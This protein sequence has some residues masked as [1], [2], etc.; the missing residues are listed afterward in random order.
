MSKHTPEPWYAVKS[1]HGIDGGHTA[2]AVIDPEA[3]DKA[4]LIVSEQYEDDDEFS[5]E[6]NA[7]RIVACVNA[8]ANIPT[9]HL[10]QHG[11]EFLGFYVQQREMEEIIVQRD[12]LK[13]AVH[14][15]TQYIKDYPFD[16]GLEDFTKSVIQKLEVAL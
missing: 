16:M 1:K 7:R 8:C 3:E 5:V 12:K 4:T 11:H 13:S 6:E 14:E 9:E 10:E 2:V 15:I